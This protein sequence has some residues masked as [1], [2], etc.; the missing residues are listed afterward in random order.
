[1]QHS[2]PQAAFEY[3]M[4]REPTITNGAPIMDV[5]GQQVAVERRGL[6]TIIHALSWKTLS[7]IDR[8]AQRSSCGFQGH[9][10]LGPHRAPLRDVG[11]QRVEGSSRRKPTI[12]HGA[13]IM[14]IGG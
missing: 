1:M 12:T 14:G 10:G 2:I 11:G 4:R 5:G 8:G 3:T 7:G 6:K 13:P 9:L